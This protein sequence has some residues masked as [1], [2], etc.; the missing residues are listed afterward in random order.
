MPQAQLLQL[1]WKHISAAESAAHAPLRPSACKEQVRSDWYPV[2]VFAQAYI[3]R[4]LEE[5][6]D[7]EADHSRLQAAQVRLDPAVAQQQLDSRRAAR[8]IFCTC[9]CSASCSPAASGAG[10]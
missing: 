5:V 3:P 6:E 8:Q 4:R 2:Q 9:K 7:H 1:L 10:S